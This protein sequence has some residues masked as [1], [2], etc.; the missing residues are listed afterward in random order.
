MASGVWLQVYLTRMEMIWTLFSLFSQTAFFYVRNRA[1]TLAYPFTIHIREEGT[2]NIDLVC[3]I[4]IFLIE[5]IF[6]NVKVF[7]FF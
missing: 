7:F 6:V 2:S 1:G 5:A 3:N 4:S